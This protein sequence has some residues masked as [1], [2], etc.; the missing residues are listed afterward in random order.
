[1]GWREK[2]SKIRRRGKE[3]SIRMLLQVDSGLWGKGQ[4]IDAYKETIRL[5]YWY[6]ERIYAK[7]YPLSREERKE[8]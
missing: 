2:S 8:V 5:Y 4:Q 3:A 7:E 6:Q 1:M